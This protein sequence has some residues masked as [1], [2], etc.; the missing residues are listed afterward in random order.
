MRPWLVHSLGRDLLGP[1]RGPDERLSKSERPDLIYSLGIL[2]P[3]ER[4]EK[5]LPERRLDMESFDEELEPKSGDEGTDAPREAAIFSPGLDPKAY[6]P[7]MGISFT[8]RSEGEPHFDVAISYARYRLLGE[9]YCR[10]PRG[11]IIPSSEISRALDEG[12]HGSV[13]LGPISK[14]TLEPQILALCDDAESEARLYVRRRKSDTDLWTIT[15]ML[16]TQIEAQEKFELDTRCERMIFQ[17]E[18]RIRLNEGT[19]QAESGEKTPPIGNL[20]EDQIDEELYRGRG[21]VARGHLCSAMWKEHDPQ[22]MS[23]N[24]RYA[25]RSQLS[26]VST[27]AHDSPPFFWVDNDHPA[28]S[29]DSEGLYPPDIRTEYIPLVN[30]PAPDMDPEPENIPEWRQ[31]ILASEL[32][33]ASTSQEI[34]RILTPLVSGYERWVN[35]TFDSSEVGVQLKTL[36][37]K[38]LKRMQK[39]LEMIARDDDARLAFNMANKAIFV[40]NRWRNPDR[41]FKWRKFQIAFA[42]SSIEST[43]NRKSSDRKDLDLLWVATG[44][45]KTEAYLLLISYLICLK[46]IRPQLDSTNTSE[47]IPWQ[48]VNVLTRYT[49]RLLTIQQFRRA[50]GVITAMEALRTGGEEGEGWL[51]AMTILRGCGCAFSQAQKASSSSGR[52]VSVKSPAWIRQSPVCAPTS[53][54]KRFL[55]PKKFGHIQK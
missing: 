20:T 42:L 29:D 52:P 51:P 7:S 46:R 43:S 5:S 28:F 39:G 50:L 37:R 14:S 19:E 10:S 25:L 11:A 13:Y 55:S 48:G 44:G 33:E 6:P 8:C 3:P 24:E 23:E 40:S 45:G 38:S 31:P 53:T 49:L 32:A 17:P 22:D 47:E 18:I 4:N 34:R 9:E 54:T 2:A 27:D 35:E 12:G 21:Q 16:T 41:S 1:I 36:A 15:L 26:E 30:L